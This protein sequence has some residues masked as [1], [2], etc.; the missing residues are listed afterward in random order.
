MKLHR[1]IIVA[2]AAGLAI[3]MVP[4]ATPSAQTPAAVNQSASAIAGKTHRVII[5]VTQND[6]AVMS[7]ALNNVENLVKYYQQKEEPVEVEFVAYGAGLHM[8][9]A[10][11][12]PVKD[13]LAAIS[14]NMKN[15]TFTGCGN[16]LANQSKMENKNISLLPEARL[17]PSGI[18]RIVEL[19][20]L[21]WSYVRP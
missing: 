1:S 12:S 8:V 11:T 17:V 3:L 4:R 15:V 9:R 13:R 2:A 21:G 20:E 5:Q 6:P 19:E 7:M 10:D 14:S 16:T 18:A